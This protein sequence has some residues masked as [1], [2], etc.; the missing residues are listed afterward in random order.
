MEKSKINSN[1]CYDFIDTNKELFDNL[2]EYNMDHEFNRDLFINYIDSQ[3]CS[4][5]YFNLIKYLYENHTYI[6]Y[7]MAL[8]QFTDNISELEEKYNEKELIVVFIQ[9]ESHKSNYY[10]TLYFLYLYRKLTGKKIEYVF[11]EENISMD[12]F[13]NPLL[14]I[15]D[16]FIYSGNQITKN[17]KKLFLCS[18]LNKKLQLFLHIIGRTEISSHKFNSIENVEI[19]Y[20]EKLFIEKKT[21][22]SLLCD[23]I[24]ENEK[25]SD[26]HLDQDGSLSTDDQKMI[27][28]Y[29]ID[30]DMYI[31][32]VEEKKLYVTGQLY[33]SFEYL[34]LSLI[35]LFFKYPDN[36]STIT[37]MCGIKDY[38]NVYTINYDIFTKKINK[39]KI[40]RIKKHKWYYKFEITP[41]M[42]GINELNDIK[43]KIILPEKMDI[44]NYDWMEQCINFEGIYNNFKK[45]FFKKSYS[46]DKPMENIELINNCEKTIDVDSAGL[47]NESI[48]PFYK[49]DPFV[50]K[51]KSFYDKNFRYSGGKT[52]KNRR[53][54][55]KTKRVGRTNTIVDR[56]KYRNR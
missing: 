23:K 34:G 12:G 42:I 17:I 24:N 31:L 54:I 25:K 8:K 14:I 28:D 1:N 56:K 50:K 3:K 13:K 5:K 35:Y 46:Y 19:I 32:N 37:T 4:P 30:N 41:E 55:R 26:F 53:K 10:F 22:L 21:I 9:K 2:K 39:D 40:A 52:R 6:S 15:C 44:S 33:N 18:C 47:C 49:S 48:K 29:I 11:F 36:L 38:K 20:P 45:I 16:D 51:L 43:T 7:D 27:E